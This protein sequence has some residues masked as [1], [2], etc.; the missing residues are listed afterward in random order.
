MPPCAATAR[1]SQLPS[2]LAASPNS[3]E[4][5]QP[6]MFAPNARSDSS[7]L[8]CPASRPATISRLCSG[9][10]SLKA[11]VLPGPTPI[12]ASSA[13]IGA[14]FA[15][16]V[17]NCRA[18]SRNSKKLLRASAALIGGKG[19]GGAG[20]GGG[21]GREGGQGRGLLAGRPG[22]AVGAWGRVEE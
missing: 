9:G 10:R 17:V 2:Y 5:R 15:A 12:R 22:P 16:G 20:G 11:K 19:E 21:G 1:F 8:P 14:S 18:K 3:P 6:L 13:R 7:T 4:R